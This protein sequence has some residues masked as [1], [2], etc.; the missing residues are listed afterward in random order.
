VFK[1]SKNGG[2]DD[3]KLYAMKV[4]K[5]ID[6]MKEEDAIQ[7]MIERQV[8]EKIGDSPFLLRLYYA[9]Q[10]DRAL[11]LIIS[12]YIKDYIHSVEPLSIIPLCIVFPQVL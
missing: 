9:F 12:E 6:M 7:L 2:A 8:Y 11:H 4:T 10:T 5:K 1:V 3:G